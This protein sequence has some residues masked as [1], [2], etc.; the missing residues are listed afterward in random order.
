[1]QTVDCT[2]IKGANYRFFLSTIAGD[3]LFK[4]SV[5][6]L[7][8]EN[9]N[10]LPM[11][12]VNSLATAFF[13]RLPKGTPLKRESI[14]PRLYLTS[15]PNAASNSVKWG[16]K[17]PMDVSE[18]NIGMDFEPFF[19]R[20]LPSMVEVSNEEVVWLNPERL[21]TLHSATASSAS[22]ATDS[23]A[24]VPSL[25]VSS[26]NKDVS[27]GG[28]DTRT[29]QT[30][31]EVAASSSM[32]TDTAPLTIDTTAEFKQLVDKAFQA[33]LS[34][35]QMQKVLTAIA[36]NPSLVH[37]SGLTP[38]RLPQIIENNPT[39]AAEFLLRLM[40][41]SQITEY[42]SE[43]VNME[44]SLHSMEVVNRLTT[45]VELPAEF[46]HLYISNCI[47]TCEKTTDKYLQ[48]RLVRLVCV[49]L[50]SLIRNKVVHVKDLFAEVQN[51]CITFSKIR[52]AAALF[53]LVKQLQ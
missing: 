16:L 5:T 19:L 3:Q 7:I 14:S 9:E 53:R 38:K 30:E 4:K 34:P 28:S 50:Q 20:P 33:P 29:A 40:S 21:T 43:L 10:L 23:S 46:I 39:L 31:N 11:P 45:L 35:A 52:E 24:T 17:E 6:E 12:D 25:S 1:L 49:F 22:S 13:E 26:S 27:V 15:V 36:K 37:V 48:N 42:F 47:S 32:A 51:F 41:S 44:M 8:E 2:S 18:F